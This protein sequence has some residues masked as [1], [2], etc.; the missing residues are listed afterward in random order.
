MLNQFIVF[1]LHI[2]IGSEKSDSKL[3]IFLRLLTL[4]MI[5]CEAHTQF[6]SLNSKHLEA[7][8]KR[9]REYRPIVRTHEWR[10]SKYLY[11]QTTK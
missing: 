11:T 4:K 8:D 2:Y 1:I 9:D 7:A 10:T 6:E 5:K 3:F